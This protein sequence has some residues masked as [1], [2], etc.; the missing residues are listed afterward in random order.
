MED[1]RDYLPATVAAVTLMTVWAGMI[2]ALPALLAVIFAELFG[3]RSVLFYFLVGGMIGLIADQVSKLAIDPVPYGG[4]T[5]I[6]L[7]A[8]FVGGF[9]YWLIAGRLAGQGGS[10]SSPNSGDSKTGTSGSKQTGGTE[11][12]AGQ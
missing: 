9:V 1:S 4:R 8:G 6:M 7:A 12:T 10:D 5:V 3:W 2:S 11:T